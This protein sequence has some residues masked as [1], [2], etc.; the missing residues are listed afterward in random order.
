MSS[1]AKYE[2]SDNNASGLITLQDEIIS[3]KLILVRLCLFHNRYQC[4]NERWELYL[5]NT[6]LHFYPKEVR[7]IETHK[8]SL[9]SYIF[10]TGKKPAS[11][12]FKNS[13]LASLFYPLVSCFLVMADVFKVDTN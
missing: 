6:L 12:S 11:A 9:I 5:C 4:R 8:Y 13:F 1:R 3:T 7:D 10:L 2:L